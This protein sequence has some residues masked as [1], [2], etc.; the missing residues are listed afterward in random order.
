LIEVT[1]ILN[2]TTG[3][4]SKVVAF[5]NIT[6]ISSSQV[7]RASEVMHTAGTALQQIVKAEL[8]RVITSATADA[9]EEV[10]RSMLAIDSMSKSMSL[11]MDQLSQKTTSKK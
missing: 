2:S 6:E 7:V 4:Q 11:M 3:L 9:D 8:K 5:S 10:R 1:S